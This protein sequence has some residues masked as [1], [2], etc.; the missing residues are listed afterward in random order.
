MAQEYTIEKISQS[1]PREWTGDYGTI[2]YIKTMLKGHGKPVE[3]GKKSPDALK[4]G[5]TVYGTIKQTD[6]DVDRFKPEKNPNTG[7]AR[8]PKD[9]AAIKAMWAIG[10]SVQVALGKGK[11]FDTKDIEAVANE[12]FGMVDRVKSPQ[13]STS[14][15]KTE[16]KSPLSEDDFQKAL[17]DSFDET[18]DIDVSQIPF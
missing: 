18:G 14:V 7:M 12:L 17:G 1:P 2:Y 8:Q 13:A 6:F 10:Q 5:D 15:E 3:V 11:T 16:A 4:T 9:E